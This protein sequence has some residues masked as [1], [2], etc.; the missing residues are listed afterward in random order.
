MKC[1]RS[2]IIDYLKMHGA[3]SLTGLDLSGHFW[4][5]PLVTYRLAYNCYY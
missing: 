1:H 5:A 3:R 4:D 2:V